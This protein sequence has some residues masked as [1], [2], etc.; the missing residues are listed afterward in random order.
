M[1]SKGL[2]YAHS[3]LES[4]S[5][6]DSKSSSSVKVLNVAKVL[7]VTTD[8]GSAFFPLKSEPNWASKV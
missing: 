8:Q 2:S 6:K 5:F 1:E 3:D 7:A 4:P